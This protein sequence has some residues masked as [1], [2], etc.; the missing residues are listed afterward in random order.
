M[1]VASFICAGVICGLAT[2]G[3]QKSRA[4]RIEG[5]VGMADVVVTLLR[6][7]QGALMTVVSDRRGQF[8][9]DGVEDGTYIVDFDL[10]G[11]NITRHHAV[12]V[13]SPA[14]ANLGLV[15]LSVGAICE[16][17][18]FPFKPGEEWTTL[19]GRV[20]DQAGR[21]VPHANLQLRGG[22]REEQA[23]SGPAGEFSANVRVGDALQMVASDSSFVAETKTL[24]VGRKNEPLILKM[25]PK[26]TPEKTG[27][28]HLRR[29]CRCAGD[30][31][32]HERR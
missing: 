5:N 1:K 20:E 29:G 17:I 30:V 14:V 23:Y 3:A 22:P 25:T 27:I 13:A 12:R 18:T 15:E 31:F 11:F 28:E 24:K 2:V 4:A 19:S 8:G 10:P 6:P 7:G 26:E 9:F 16:C 32:F 21:P